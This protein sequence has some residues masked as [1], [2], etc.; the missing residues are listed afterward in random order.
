MSESP[1]RRFLTS[2]RAPP[3]TSPNNLAPH[4]MGS[5]SSLP[6]DPRRAESCAEDG[7]VGLAFLD[8][9]SERNVRRMLVYDKEKRPIL[10]VPSHRPSLRPPARP[11]S[12]GLRAA[13]P[14]ARDG[15]GPLATRAAPGPARVGRG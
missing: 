1:S 6:P 2:S 9:R 7:S 4:C 10:Q 3:P 13:R 11:H 12:P 5:L 15:G 14:P 8:S